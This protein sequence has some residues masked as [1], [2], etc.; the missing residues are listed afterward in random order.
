MTV[1]MS[2]LDLRSFKIK[3]KHMKFVNLIL[4]GEIQKEIQAKIMSLNRKFNNY[5]LCEICLK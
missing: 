4:K 3:I 1:K 2:L 5:Y